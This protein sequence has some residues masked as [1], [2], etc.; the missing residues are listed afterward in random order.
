M[1]NQNSQPVKH[2]I[3]TTNHRQLQHT[4][5]SSVNKRNF[6]KTSIR[7]AQ[8]KEPIPLSHPLA[9][10]I[11]EVDTSKSSHAQGNSGGKQIT[12]DANI[13]VIN[14]TTNQVDS[15]LEFE[16]SLHAPDKSQ[17]CKSISSLFNCRKI[18]KN[19]TTR[20]SRKVN[21]SAYNETTKT[22]LSK[23]NPTHSTNVA[24]E[25]KQCST[26]KRYTSDRIAIG[27]PRPRVE[28][29]DE[30]R[31]SANRLTPLDPLD[32]LE[33]EAHHR[34]IQRN[35]INNS[36]RTNQNNSHRREKSVLGR[37]TSQQGQPLHQRL[38]QKASIGKISHGGSV[39]SEFLGPQA[40]EKCNSINIDQKYLKKCSVKRQASALNDQNRPVLSEGLAGFSMSEIV[41]TLPSESKLPGSDLAHSQVASNSNQASQSPREVLDEEESMFERPLPTPPKIDK[42]SKSKLPSITLDSEL[43]TEI[44][45]QTSWKK[46]VSLKT[47]HLANIL[48]AN[49]AI[50]IMTDYSVGKKPLPHQQKTNEFTSSNNPIAGLLLTETNE[51]LSFYKAAKSG[52]IRRGMAVALLEAQA[53]TGSLID[54]KTARRMTVK[55][56]TAL[57]LLD[58]L[59]E[60]VVSRAE[61]AVT[62]YSMRSVDGTMSI[63][64]ALQHGLILEAHGMR[65]ME[66]Q[67][68]TG[69]LI[70]PRNNIRVP[71]KTAI[72][73]E[74][75]D[76]MILDVFDAANADTSPSNKIK[77]EAPK[78]FKMFYDPNSEENVTYRELIKRCIVDEDSGLILLPLNMPMN[79]RRR[80]VS[81]RGSTRSSAY[82]S[83]TGSCS[84]IP[85]YF[86][87]NYGFIS[88]KAM[89]GDDKSE[90]E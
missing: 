82:S 86:K 90:V 49:E 3:I 88:A 70:D 34:I 66:V 71:T 41:E 52:A 9:G 40:I 75:I 57:G 8:S 37:R 69:G 15:I 21:I 72:E 31:A 25:D 1:G 64:D 19:H 67:L 78:N 59:Y 6:P 36:L 32:E 17:L 12:I 85:D 58:K 84:S 35:S 10:P 60:N 63:Y 18:V 16:R 30:N 23:K 14:E 76:Q 5:S 89:E 33:Q 56:A 11:Q 20:Y 13:K 28:I 62:G 74:L 81:R 24:V 4:Q 39:H 68:A 27:G 26:L 7:R 2:T 44:K 73:R 48:T 79:E 77:N 54:P 87:Y 46:E 22:R 38:S 51:K 80:S 65:L 47:L 83:R 43:F 45:Y 50:E 61:R 29:R 55:E 53:A 42:I